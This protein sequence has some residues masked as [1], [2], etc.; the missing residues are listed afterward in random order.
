MFPWPPHLLQPAVRAPVAVD[1][2]LGLL[3]LG[4]GGTLPGPGV[5]P[6][7][8]QVQQEPQ[9]LVLQLPLAILYW[10][11]S[12]PCWGKTIWV[13]T[14]FAVGPLS[15]LHS[16]QL[17]FSSSTSIS[18]TSTWVWSTW[19]S[20]SSSSS[21]S[22]SSMWFVSTFSGFGFI[23][24]SPSSSAPRFFSSVSWSSSSSSLWSW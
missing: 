15:L 22:S 6:L 4:L 17:Y 10:V 16:Y 13:I 2:C 12:Q 24:N 3:L 20:W 18:D 9:A 23:D 5:S 7:L 11:G 1:R 21:S 14:W 19:S 8:Q